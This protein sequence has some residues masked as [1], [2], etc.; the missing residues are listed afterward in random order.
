M[1]RISG[2]KYEVDKFI[3]EELDCND[4]W[5]EGCLLSDCLECLIKQYNLE[6][7]YDLDTNK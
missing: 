5:R 3:E 1:I 2:E 4:G 6:V 7:T